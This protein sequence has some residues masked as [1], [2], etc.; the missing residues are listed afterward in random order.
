MPGR[1]EVA[2]DRKSQEKVENMQGRALAESRV[3][4]ADQLQ[5]Q[6]CSLYL[7]TTLSSDGDAALLL[8]RY[9]GL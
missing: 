4:V 8:P 2:A 7:Y 1:A 3:L 6:M 9:S 5:Y